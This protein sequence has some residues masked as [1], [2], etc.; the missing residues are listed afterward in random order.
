MP[1]L[2][3]FQI[4][5]DDEYK[6]KTDLPP[7]WPSQITSKLYFLT[8]YR[9]LINTHMSRI[10]LPRKLQWLLSLMTQIDGKHRTIVACNNKPIVIHLK[11][12]HLMY[13]IK[14]K[15]AYIFPPNFNKSNTTVARHWW[16]RTASPSGAPVVTPG[17]SGDRIAQS[18]KCFVNQFVQ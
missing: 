2:P 13:T 9:V 18:L 7:L 16:K 1:I 6:L 4:H 3:K 15:P 11:A 12:Y 5:I 17:F 8:L 10:E 14:N